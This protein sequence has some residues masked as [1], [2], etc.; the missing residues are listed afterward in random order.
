M[1]KIGL[2]RI[3]GLSTVGLLLSC[4]LGCARLAPK[5]GLPWQQ[6]EISASP[7]RVWEAVH[8]V[9]G[10]APIQ[11][12]DRD[13]GILRTGWMQGQ[14]KGHSGPRARGWQRRS[15]FVIAVQPIDGKSLMTVRG[16]AQEQTLLGHQGPHWRSIRS[17]G[18]LD[19]DFLEQVKA[20]LD[21]RKGSS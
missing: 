15:R 7:D 16:E 10:D 3:L 5:V 6:M 8:G 14:G 1:G 19:V 11:F 9:L 21:S 13:E 4:L 20:Q 12:E 17:D 2:K 18:S